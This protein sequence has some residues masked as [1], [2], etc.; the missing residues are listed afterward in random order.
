MNDRTLIFIFLALC[1][2]AGVGILFQIM[3]KNPTTYSPQFAVSQQEQ[4]INSDILTPMIIT[5]PA[6]Q[7]G[8]PI[9]SQ[10]TCDGSNAHPPLIFSDV[11]QHAQ[12]L[13]LIMDDP[14]VPK[15]IRPDGMWDHWIV[16]NMPAHTREIAEGARANGVYGKNTGG[17]NEYGG[18]CPPDREH[19][20]FFKLYALDTLLNVAEGASKKEVEQAMQGHILAQAE[21][22]GT[23]DR[24][25]Q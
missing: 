11:P 20:Y 12:S 10:Y 8:M 15:N 18:P 22:M 2:I 17:K 9:P 1:I 5:S 6:F 16:F 14:D 25:A 4:K 21:L 24:S 7:Q 23:Y 19:R 3:K 13:V